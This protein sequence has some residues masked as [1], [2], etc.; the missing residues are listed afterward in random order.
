MTASVGIENHLT[1]LPQGSLSRQLQRA[2]IF[3]G[4]CRWLIHLY[5]SI[6]QI[7]IHLYKIQTSHLLRCVPANSLQRIVLHLLIAHDSILILIDILFLSLL[8]QTF[9]MDPP[10]FRNHIGNIDPILFIFAFN[11]H[12]TV[13]NIHGI[14]GQPLHSSIDLPYIVLS[15]ETIDQIASHKSQHSDTFAL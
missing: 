6:F 12:F 2:C 9:Q 7:R 5:R 11:V 8:Y 14:H 4:K 13:H 15:C 1:V 10:I 3:I